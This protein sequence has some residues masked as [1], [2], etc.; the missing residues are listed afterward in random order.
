VDRSNSISNPNEM[1][2]V[3][4]GIWA[5]KQLQQ[6][7]SLLILWKL[8]TAFQK[9]G[10]TKFMAVTLSNLNWYSTYYK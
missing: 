5:L 2:A 3:T 8:A 4:K 7:P 6:K 9:K 10:D 1:V